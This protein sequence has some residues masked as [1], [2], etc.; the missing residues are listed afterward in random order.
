MP[1][2]KLL[3]PMETNQPGY[4]H[5]EE[6]MDYAQQQDDSCAYCE[7]VKLMLGFVQP[8]LRL[9]MDELVDAK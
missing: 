5:V 4:G 7:N 1:G 8:W 2:Q 3:L 9:C 6:D